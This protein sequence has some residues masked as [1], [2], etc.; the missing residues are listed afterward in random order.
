ME[1]PLVDPRDPNYDSD[2][3]EAIVKISSL[4]SLIPLAV[5]ELSSRCTSLKLSEHQDEP[6]PR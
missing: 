3:H 5:D 1:L 6:V 4:N 2:R